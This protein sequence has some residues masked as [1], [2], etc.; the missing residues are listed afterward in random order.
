MMDDLML[1]KIEKGKQLGK[2][3]SFITE[4]RVV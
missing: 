1:C 2:T 4:E 3:F